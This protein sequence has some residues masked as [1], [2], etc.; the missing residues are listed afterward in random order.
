MS[1]PRVYMDFNG[2]SLHSTKTLNDLR[3]QGL[4]LRAGMQC[5]FYQDDADEDGPGFLHSTGSVWYN[6]KTGQFM[7][8]M[9]TVDLRFTHGTHLSILDSLYP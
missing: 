8:D 3:R 1:L 2:Y 4:E 6:E 5:V 7:L 9:R